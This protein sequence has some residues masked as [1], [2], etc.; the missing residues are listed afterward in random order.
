MKAI[1]EVYQGEQDDWS[2]RIFKNHLDKWV[3]F[4]WKMD[5]PI[6]VTQE[7]FVATGFQ[8]DRSLKAND[9]NVSRFETAEECEQELLMM[10]AA[11]KLSG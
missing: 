10:F 9:P 8:K 5:R 2:Y 11:D 7:W 6:F 3:A 4:R 1:P